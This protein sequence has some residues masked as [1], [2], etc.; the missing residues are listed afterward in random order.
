MGFGN[1]VLSESVRKTP[2]YQDN[3][4]KEKKPEKLKYDEKIEIPKE[5]TK[6][7]KLNKI[8]K[9]INDVHSRFNF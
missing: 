5:F 8:D 9:V 6:A 4:F 3:Q 7:D 1:L 2:Q